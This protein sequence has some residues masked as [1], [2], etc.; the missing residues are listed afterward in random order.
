MFYKLDNIHVEV[1]FFAT[2][3]DRRGRVI[4][5]REKHNVFTDVGRDWLAHLVAWEALGDPDTPK[6]NA[7]VRWAAL[8]T[9]L[10]QLEEASV[11]QLEV[12]TRVDDS[13][14]YLVAIQSSTYIAPASPGDRPTM[15]FKKEFSGLEIT[16]ETNPVVSISEAGLFVD[17]YKAD[18]PPVGIGGAD[19]V[20]SAGLNTI[21]DP[22]FATNSPVAY[23]RFD[24]LT[25]TQDFIFE[26]VW[27]FR[28]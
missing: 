6:T 26:I 4:D 14:N 1:N 21:L 11:I 10:T 9:G 23:A 3:R 16:T 28:F 24:P 27:D 18:A 13:G 15:R 12:P 5:R 2:L 22:T 19:D 7:R 8:G 25:K 20:P 17:V